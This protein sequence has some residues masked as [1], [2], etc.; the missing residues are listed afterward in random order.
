MRTSEFPYGK[1]TKTLK[2]AVTWLNRNKRKLEKSKNQDSFDFDDYWDMPRSI[3]YK[4]G[5]DEVDWLQSEFS[6]WNHEHN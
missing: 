1:V 4:L 6:N 5:C 2:K 3:S